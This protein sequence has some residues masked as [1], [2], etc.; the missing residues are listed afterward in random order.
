[1]KGGMLKPD[2]FS[3]HRLPGFPPGIYALLITFN[4][5]HNY[6]AG[7]LERINGSGRFGP[8]PRLSREAAERKIDKDLFNTA[9]LVT[10]GLYVNITSQIRIPKDDPQFEL[11]SRLRLGP[12]PARVLLPSFRQ[13]RFLREHR[14]PGLR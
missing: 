13:G 2:T 11:Y 10:C 7:E 1:M 6:V 5:F 3:E 4:R 8:N 12:G 14:Q 9:R